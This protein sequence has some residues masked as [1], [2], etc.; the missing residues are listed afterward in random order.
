MLPS[1]DSGRLKEG[2]HTELDGS[3][4]GKENIKKRKRANNVRNGSRVSSDHD[5]CDLIPS[6][7]LNKEKEVENIE[8]DNNLLSDSPSRVGFSS[9][10]NHFNERSPLASSK[11]TQ[12]KKL[13]IKNF[14]GLYKLYIRSDI[15]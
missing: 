3:D 8:E 10:I 6:K 13:V 11:P 9:F 4:T 12:T 7:K 1:G 5:L 15:R 14:K 2:R